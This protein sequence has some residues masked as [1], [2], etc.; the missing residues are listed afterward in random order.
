MY[1]STQEVTKTTKYLPLK[2]LKKIKNPPCVS[3]LLQLWWKIIHMIEMFILGIFQVNLDH[4]Y[5][6]LKPSTGHC[7]SWHF[8]CSFDTC[9]ILKSHK[10]QIQATEISCHIHFWFILLYKEKRGPNGPILAYIDVFGQKCNH[11]KMRFF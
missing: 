10:H 4:T 8:S 2:K 1:K 7:G 3:F 11:F 6:S 5:S 9:R